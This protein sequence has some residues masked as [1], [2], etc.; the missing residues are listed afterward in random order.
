MLI[1]REHAYTHWV[2]P[3]TK[4][5]TFPQEDNPPAGGYPTQ[6]AQF[7]FHLQSHRRACLFQHFLP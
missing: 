2:V 4:D 6:I 3:I 5:F 1:I 7:R